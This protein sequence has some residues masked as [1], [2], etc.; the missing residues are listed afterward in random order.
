MSAGLTRLSSMPKDRMT[1]VLHQLPPD[2]HASLSRAVAENGAARSAWPQADS[3]SN[4][5]GKLDNGAIVRVNRGLYDHV[6]IWDAERQRVIENDGHGITAVTLDQ[7]RSGGRISS[8]PTR[9]P[10]AT[11]ER[12]RSQ[13]GVGGYDLAFNNCE[14][15]ANWAATGKRSSPQVRAAELGGLS[16][17][18]GG[19]SAIPTALG[20][21]ISARAPAANPVDDRQMMIA[22]A[23]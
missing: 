6:G 2:V 10:T 14:H 21:N 23:R 16:L 15:F 7:F 20:L 9:D 4:G 13:I 18:F 12:A 8:E 22:A 17:L 5:G 1:A 11:V 3:F 19:P